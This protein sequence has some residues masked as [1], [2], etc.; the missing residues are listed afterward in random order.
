[1][2][3]VELSTKLEV[4][5]EFKLQLVLGSKK[6]QLWPHCVDFTGRRTWWEWR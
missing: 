3:Y 4:K 5:L 1:M 6:T 2:A